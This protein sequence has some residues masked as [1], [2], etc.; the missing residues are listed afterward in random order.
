M[1]HWLVED[2][3]KYQL[4]QTANS[5]PATR[6][7]MIALATVH[8]NLELQREGQRNDSRLSQE[9][10]ARRLHYARQNYNIAVSELARALRDRT[11]AEEVALMVCALFVFYNFI[12]GNF[13]TAVF[14]MHN[15]IEIMSRWKAS[16]VGDRI[17]RE[18]SLE[19]NLIT[20]FGRL[21]YQSSSLDDPTPT[22]EPQIP[23]VPSFSTLQAAKVSLYLLT[24]EG[25][26]M[27]RIGAVLAHNPQAT[28]RWDDLDIQTAK[29]LFALSQWH[30]KF[31]NLVASN[32][33]PYSE[34]DKGSISILRIMHLASHIWIWAILHPPGA[35]EPTSMLEHFL[36]LVEELYAKWT[37]GTI[38]CPDRIHIFD[39]GIVPPLN[40]VTRKGTTPL[41]ERARRLLLKAAP[42]I[43][44]DTNSIPVPMD[45]GYTG[46]NSLSSELRPMSLETGVADVGEDGMVEVE[47][48]SGATQLGISLKAKRSGNGWEIRKDFAV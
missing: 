11:D 45:S 42:L 32:P 39:M 28:E 26:R 29:Y 7:A 13:T 35:P 27:V 23:T 25:I 17:L 24:R 46:G 14:H 8:E 2:F 36:D 6:H 34:A 37:D 47:V 5:E 10:V 30:S 18:G 40:F 22:P 20:L 15:G 3:W 33:T 16:K 21:S 9:E 1:S 12:L 38:S 41:K 44:L 19:K 43:V 31:E 48:E 4:P